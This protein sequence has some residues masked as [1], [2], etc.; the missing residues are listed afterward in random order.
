M[1]KF[2][3]TCSL[4]LDIERLAEEKEPFY[5]SSITLEELEDIKVSSH[6]DYDIKYM[7]R[8]T[9]R[10]L[11]N[12]PEGQYT[13]LIYSHA[14]D[15][16][17]EKA[18][19]PMNNDSKILISLRELIKGMKNERFVFVSN[20]LCAK[21]IAKK[22][23]SI[24]TMSV[25]EDYDDDYTGYNEVWGTE[26]YIASFYA[27][28][29][30][31]RFDEVYTNSYLIL[32]F[33]DGKIVDKFKWDGTQYI[34]LKYKEFSSSWFGNVKPMRNDVYQACAAD[35]LAN[36]Q[37]T[38]LRGKAGSGKSYLALGYL[39]SMFER[40]EIEKIIIFCNPVAT[41]DAARLGFYPGDKNDKLMDS[42]IGNFLVSKFGGRVFV[43]KLIQEE[44][45]VLLPMSDIR[46]F[47]T[48]GMRAGVYI[49]EAQNMSVELMKLALQ[50][51]GEDCICVIDGD[52]RAQV[53][54]VN[55]AGANNGIKRLSKV[56]RGQPFYGE[57][58]LQTI[59][60]SKIA[61]IADLM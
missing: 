20:D 25:R 19:I 41:K 45:I 39:A 15:E 8:K 28:P 55:F 12:L 61:L 59:Y 21:T 44:K 27:D 16:R 3:D 29:T 57:V 58:T 54:D 1:I 34:P 7:A 26:E 11:D 31:K 60:R 18:G 33:E 2:Y 51:I 35:S 49:T 4:L 23:L 30:D 13:T 32:R 48:S 9:L 47:D 50:R 6:K 5:I 43:D 22:V 14:L 10:I 46:G 36:N 56:F 17:I 24:D 42:Q 38:L 37:I 52:D 40:Q 53:D